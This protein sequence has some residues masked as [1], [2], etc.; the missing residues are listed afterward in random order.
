[1]SPPAAMAALRMGGSTAPSITDLINVGRLILDNCGIEFGNRKLFR[2]V[3]DFSDRAP[4]ASGYVFFNYLTAA[5]QISEAQKRTALSNPDLARV[6]A[7][8]DPT[9]ETAVNRAMKGNR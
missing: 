1:M 7:Y 5:V 2:L 4:N 3:H 6:I 8:S 9:G